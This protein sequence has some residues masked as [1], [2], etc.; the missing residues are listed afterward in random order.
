MITPVWQEKSRMG[1]WKNAMDRSGTTE[2]K[3]LRLVFHDCIPYEDGTG[4][5][6]G[7]LNWK[8][9]NAPLRNVFTGKKYSFE[10][11][12]K[13]SNQLLDRTAEQLEK[14]YKSINWPY[15][16]PSLDVSLHQS[17]KSRADLWQFA[18]LVALEVAIE[19]AN[20]ACDLDYHQRQQVRLLEGRKECEI[21]LTKPLK[22]MTG[23]KD[24]K[25]SYKT[26]KP[27]VC[28]LKKVH[29]LRVEITYFFL[30]NCLYC[31]RYFFG[32]TDPHSLETGVGVWSPSLRSTEIWKNF[33]INA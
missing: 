27:E 10:P 22:F 8:G 7:C 4:G 21:K 12:K 19:R 23:R 18:G 5:C 26:Y 24:K 17:G 31:K 1:L 28:C 29:F 15:V 11:I 6:D 13:T 3:V 32:G 2:N 14:I 25:K 33:E 20:R 30:N 9:M 16:K